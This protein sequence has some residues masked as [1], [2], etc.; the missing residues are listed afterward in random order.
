M[1]V[2]SLPILPTTSCSRFYPYTGRLLGECSRVHK[3]LAHSSQQL[4]TLSLALP[5]KSPTEPDLPGPFYSQPRLPSSL[6]GL[7]PCAWGQWLLLRYCFLYC[8]RETSPPALHPMGGVKKISLY[9]C[10]VTTCPSSLAC[11]CLYGH[12]LFMD[13]GPSSSGKSFQISTP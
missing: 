3:S 9:P 13:R 4:A 12:I 10:S 11:M 6:T 5:T 8:L 1:Q 2:A 7:A